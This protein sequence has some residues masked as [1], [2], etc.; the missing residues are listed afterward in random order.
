MDSDSRTLARIRFFQKQVFQD[1][2]KDSMSG[3]N[4][5]PVIKILDAIGYTNGKDYERQ[6]PVGEK[7]V[8]D[9]AFVK[10]QVAL[11]VDGRNHQYG[12]QKSLDK[13]RDRYFRENNWVPIRIKDKDLFGYKMSFYKNLI[14]EV[15][16]DRREQYE[17]GRL[18]PI[19]FAN[20][21]EHDY[22]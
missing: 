1:E 15:V 4:E 20:Y 5:E 13:K 18:Y 19:D 10:E 2:W 6:F 14:K 11:E 7:F 8:I 12:R 22:E 21:V 17:T 9:F 16:E 3:K